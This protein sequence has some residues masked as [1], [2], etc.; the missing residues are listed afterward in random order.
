MHKKSPS[1]F[2]LRY[3]SRRVLGTMEEKEF[4]KCFVNRNHPV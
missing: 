1:Q 3:L 2:I 4:P